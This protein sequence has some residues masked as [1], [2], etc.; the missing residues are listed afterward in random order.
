MEKLKTLKRFL[1]VVSHFCFFSYD[2]FQKYEK[3]KKV[4]FSPKKVNQTKIKDQSKTEGLGS[5]VCVVR[6]PA[7]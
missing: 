1:C 3:E 4:F 2:A 6:T 5:A 7:F